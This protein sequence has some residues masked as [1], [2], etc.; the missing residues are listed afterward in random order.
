MWKTRMITVNR[1]GS[2]LYVL[3]PHGMTSHFI[4]RDPEHILAWA[5]HPSGG[6]HFY[7][8]R[9]KSEEVAVVGRDVLVE[10]GHCNYLAGGTD[11]VVNDT[12][13]DEH[14]NQKLHLFHA[15]SASVTPLAALA[16]TPAYTGPWRC[17]THP[18][19]SRDGSRV[20][21]D[22]AHAG[23]RQIYEFDVSGLIRARQ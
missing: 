11:W 15:P 21:V 2:D 5:Y 22:S 17:D 23:G 1:D 3:N 14:G 7:L 13:P 9:D 19:T 20:F 4:W 10:D 16:T 8:F 12:Y 6:T 18:R